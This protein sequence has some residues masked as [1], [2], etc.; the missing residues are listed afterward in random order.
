MMGQGPPVSVWTRIV[1]RVLLLPERPRTGATGVNIFRVVGLNLRV[2]GLMSPFG[3]A[4][5]NGVSHAI[6]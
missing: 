6:R 3:S 5:Y 4:L 1:L 2:V